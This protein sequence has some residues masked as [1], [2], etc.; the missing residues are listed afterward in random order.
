MYQGHLETLSNREDWERDCE[1]YDPA[2]SEPIDLTGAAIVVHVT[3]E[4]TPDDAVLTGSTSDGRVT[5]T[6]PGTF[7]WHF[8][9]GDVAGLCEGTYRAFVRVTIAGRTKQLFAGTLPVVHGGPP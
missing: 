4:A 2:T 9:P 5:I 3:R 8:T 6:G 7:A 1:L